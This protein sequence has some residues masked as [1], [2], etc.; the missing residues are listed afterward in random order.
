MD[1]RVE[2]PHEGVGMDWDRERRTKSQGQRW[3]VSRT[4]GL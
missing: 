4:D 1:E 3:L 2:G